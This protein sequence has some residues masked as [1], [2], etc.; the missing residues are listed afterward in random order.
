MLRKGEVS[1]PNSFSADCGDF[2]LL[3]E[4]IFVQS[5]LYKVVT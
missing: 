5:N 3:I 1:H 4:W 2:T